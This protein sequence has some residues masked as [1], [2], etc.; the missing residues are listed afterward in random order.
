[1]PYVVFEVAGV[2]AGLG[3]Y[4]ADAPLDAALGNLECG[5][6]GGREWKLT[7]AGGQATPVANL[8]PSLL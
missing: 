4:G 2:K 8:P 5:D 7:R 6:D 1:V 3:A